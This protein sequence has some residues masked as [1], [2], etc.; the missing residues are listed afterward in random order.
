MSLLLV[1]LL[2][3][4]L[5]LVAS[6]Y[7]WK[8]AL[9]FTL[10]T[11]FLQDPI[12]KLAENDSSYFGILAFICFFTCF[13]LLKSRHKLWYIDYIC[14]SNPR[15]ISLLPIFFYL[16]ILQAFNSYARFGDL[17]LSTAG[18]FFY[19]LPV[20][21]LWVGFHIGTDPRLLRNLLTTYVMFCSI[22]AISIL[23]GLFGFENNLL[24]EVG[25]GLEIT[26]LDRVGQSGLWRT[27]E[28]AGWHLA[29]GACFSFILGITETKG[30]QQN[31]YFFITIAFTLLSTSTGRRKA[32]GLVILFIAVYLLYY[33]MNVNSSKVSR[34]LTTFSLVALASFISYE[35]FLGSADQSVLDPY[36]DRSSTI[37]V[38]QTQERFGFQG[39]GAFVK[40]LEIAGPLGFGVGAGANAGSTGFGGS[41]QSIQ[42]LGY[43][44]EGGGGRIVAEL[45]GIGIA[46]IGF[47]IFNIVIL[48]LKNFKFAKYYLPSDVLLTLIGLVIFSIVNFITFFTASQLYN[49]FF[50]LILIG[51][52]AGT[53]LA[54]PI[55]ASQYREL[56]GQQYE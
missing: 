8:G 26:G 37:T 27:S 19:I 43:V 4:T 49:D 31:I 11:G 20:T 7:D 22:F 30:F 16:I 54:V 42:S 40:G 39:I 18:V 23:L 56:D 21:A 41:R 46:I 53:F 32:L 12:R 2:L 1:T 36:L 5:I 15:V 6:E 55:L 50:V 47:L 35:V 48:Y 28:I 45:G 44:S 24:K 29:A 25:G 33:S 17:I 9:F 52:S 10:V 34:I 38:E 14:W 13:M 3:L 51:I